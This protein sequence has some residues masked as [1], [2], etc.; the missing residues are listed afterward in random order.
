MLRQIIGLKHILAVLPIAVASCALLACGDDSAAGNNSQ[1]DASTGNSNQQDAGQT[2]GYHCG[3][4]HPD[5]LL[6]EDFEQGG[7]DFA[8]WFAQS[9]FVS[10]N[11]E[12]DRGRIDLSNERRPAS[13]CTTGMPS[14]DAA[15][16]PAS[17]E[18]TSPTTS[19]ASGVSSAN[20]SSRRIIAVPV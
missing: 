6:C 11:G 15:R 19:T 16:A 5:W 17:V 4:W 14:F 9:D 10:A 3:D 12:D 8:T 20:N 13:K 2:T 1:P 7:G 18:F